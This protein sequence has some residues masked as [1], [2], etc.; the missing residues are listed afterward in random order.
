MTQ[1][2]GQVGAGESRY[3]R[4]YCGVSGL[5]AGYSDY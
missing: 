1:D 3:S 5:N 4:L 2:T